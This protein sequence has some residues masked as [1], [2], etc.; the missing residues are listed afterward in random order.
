VLARLA[1]DHALSLLTRAL[2][3]HLRD[4]I[5][6]YCVGA[7]SI[8]RLERT[9]IEATG[10][11]TWSIMR[12]VQRAQRCDRHFSEVPEV[13]QFFAIISSHL[14]RVLGIL[15]IVNRDRSRWPG[16]QHVNALI[17]RGIRF[18]H[19]AASSRTASQTLQTLRERRV[20]SLGTRRR[21]TRPAR[22][23]SKNFLSLSAA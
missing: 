14:K 21:E 23:S 9:R 1:L 6:I 8:E 16:R 4:F 17:M 19:F 11:C 3:L 20:T 18:S 13:A 2:A 7:M 22:D 12:S 10:C 5:H 15:S